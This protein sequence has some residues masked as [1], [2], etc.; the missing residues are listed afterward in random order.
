M[1]L[2]GGFLRIGRSCSNAGLREASTV[3]PLKWDSLYN[4]N[5]NIIELIQLIQECRPDPDQLGARGDDI[6]YAKVCGAMWA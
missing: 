4:I 3:I 5:I 1:Q 6:R 2:L